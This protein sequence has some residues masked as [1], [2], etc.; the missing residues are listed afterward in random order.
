MC[1]V[2]DVVTCPPAPWDPSS[3][4]PMTV[5]TP[6][7]GHY[8]TTFF[9]VDP[10]SPSGRYVVVTRVPFL[11]RIPYPGDRASVCVIDRVER[12]CKTIYVT[13]G[14]GAQLGAN[15]QWGSSDDVVYCN[16][17]ID[18]VATGVAIDVHTSQARP[19]DGPIFGLTPD[20]RYSYSADLT[21]INAGIPGYGVP[22]GLIR[23]RRHRVHRSRT[24]GIWVT[25][26]HSGRRELFL[27]ISEI[28]AQLP[29]QDTFAGGFYYVFNVKVSPT[30]E[31]LLA[32]IFTKGARAAPGWPPQLVTSRL[33]GTN[34]SLAMPH[35][36]W[37]RGGNH[38]NWAPDGDHIVM[39]LTNESGHMEFVRFRSDGEGLE[40]IAP[41]HRG[42][43]HPSLDP[44]G[45]YLLTDAYVNEGFMDQHGY[46]PLRLIHLPSNTGSILTRVFTKRLMGPRRIDPHPVWSEGG[47]TICFNCV[48]R[49]KRQVVLADMSRVCARDSAYGGGRVG[50]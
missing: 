2:G 47:R 40:T 43:G 44:S 14:W 28:V 45:E 10:V 4:A 19:L 36:R 38:P 17:V 18:G 13:R 32:I 30:S 3:A 25:D 9:D 23:K 39:N 5:V 33:D 41:G 8:M 1:R 12:T 21:F 16:D 35:R 29:E 42:S 20:K 46:V 27:S 34:V 49:G 22:E 50:R 15:A 11:W 7:D 37:R 24:D 26:L 31:R 48:I 6:P